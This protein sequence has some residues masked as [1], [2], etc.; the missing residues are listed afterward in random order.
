MRT[1]S[2]LW[3]TAQAVI[4]SACFAALFV[5]SNAANP[6]LPIYRDVL[7]LDPLTVSATHVL[8]VVALTATL[9][10]FTRPALTRFASI[11]LPLSLAIAIGADLLLAHTDVW[12]LLVGRS[13]TGLSTGIGTGA[14]AALVVAAIGAKGRGLVATGNLVGA[15]IGSSGSQLAVSLLHEDAPAVV[16][17]IHAS[18]LALLLAAAAVVLVRRRTENHVA[19]S[20]P[21][22]T[23]T[24]DGNRPPRDPMAVRAFVTGTIAWIFTSLVTAL[25]A[26]LFYDLGMHATQAVGPTLFLGMSAAAQ[27]T[28]GWLTRVAPW[29][30]GMVIMGAGAAAMVGGGLLAQDALAIVGFAILGLGAGT[31]YRAGLVALTRG[32]SPA[33]QGAQSSLYSAITYGIACVA[34]LGVGVA[35]GGIG[36]EWATLIAIG[37]TAVASVVAVAWAPRLRDTRD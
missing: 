13:V 8:Y 35:G 7:A 16:F 24:D 3:T 28:S 6:L 4:V 19:L 15:V 20:I 32:S 31:A 17:L 9:L 25:T 27:L 30:S 2:P 23:I 22:V 14:A 37:A 18:L 26:T 36:L 29:L 1:P 21:T 5:G 10:V 12:S 11:L 34:V 33:R